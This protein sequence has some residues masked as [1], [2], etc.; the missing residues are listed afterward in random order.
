MNTFPNDILMLI[1]QLSMDPSLMKLLWPNKYC[2][3][4]IC[5]YRNCC[6]GCCRLRL[7]W[8][9]FNKQDLKELFCSNLCKDRFIDYMISK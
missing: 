3:K 9:S 6:Y 5:T 7:Y 8:N 1:V 4:K 2:H